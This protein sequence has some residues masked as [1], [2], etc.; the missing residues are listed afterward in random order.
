MLITSDGSNIWACAYINGVK[1]V[2][3]ANANGCQLS[4]GTT[5]QDLAQRNY[6]EFQCGGP[7]GVNTDREVDCWIKSIRVWSCQNWATTQCYGTLVTGE[8]EQPAVKRRMYAANDNEA[9]TLARLARRLAGR[10]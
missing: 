5:A 9:P 7:F 6:M 3:P 1:V 10:R 8:S 4:F 2:D